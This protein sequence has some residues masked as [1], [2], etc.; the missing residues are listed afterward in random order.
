M[1]NISETFADTA[2]TLITSFT[3]EDS[4]T[5]T[6]FGDITATSE[7]NAAGTALRRSDANAIAAHYA[8]VGGNP[9]SIAG[10]EF[11]IIV[12]FACYSEL[13]SGIALGN[14]TGTSFLDFDGYLFHVN[15]T[16]AFIQA[17]TNASYG[18]LSSASLSITVNSSSPPDYRL[19][20]RGGSQGR[21]RIYKESSLNAGDWSLVTSA[22]YRPHTGTTLFGPWFGGSA[23]WGDTAGL[24]IKAYDLTD[25]VT[26][27]DTDINV[28]CFGNSLTQGSGATTPWPLL[29]EAELNPNTG[30][31][32]NN[33]CVIQ[34]GVSA[35]T[36]ANLL[37]D[38]PTV[39]APFAQTGYAKNILV[40][41][42]GT[43]SIIG[44]QTAAQCLATLDELVE[45]ALADYD[46]VVIVTCIPSGA[47]T[48]GDETDRLAYNTGVL[49]RA[50][51][52]GGIWVADPCEDAV[53]DEET[54]AQNSTYYLN[55]PTDATHLKNA[56]YVVMEP[57]IRTAVEEAAAYTP[58]A[59]STR[60]R[61]GRINRT[62]RVNRV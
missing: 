47:I 52:S 55:P 27:I 24:H 43:N 26:L 20:F 17:A 30:S 50:S 10:P 32:D 44:G 60:P 12:T 34:K 56:G 4:Q 58:P 14:S 39:A 37:S 38:Y 23:G 28:V 33:Y 53:F 22:G 42:E 48:G 19:K 57:Y 41:Q 5:Y 59:T 9:A 16:N 49:A 35:K 45:L 40:I 61:G 29:M 18:T 62:S 51:E 21:L 31:T 1:A 13:G 25:S 2:G 3:G 11:E 7:I 15:G 54:D 36:L 8:E 46:A 6:A